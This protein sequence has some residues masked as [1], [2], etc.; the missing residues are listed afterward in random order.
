VNG[1]R[2]FCLYTIAALV[3]ASGCSKRTSDG[4]PSPRAAGEGNLPA[5]ECPLREAGVDPQHLKPFED[6]EKYIAFLDRPDRAVWQKPDDVVRA[7]Q[8]GG[9]E[10]IADVGAGSGYFT[11]RFAAALPRG[12]VVAI[13]IEPEMIRHIHHK[14]MTE[15]VTNIEPVLASVDDP[16]VPATAD[17]VF[18]CDV[19]HHVQDRQAWLERLHDQMKPGARLVL[20]EFKE[21]DLPE[22][23]PAALKISH[24]D[25]LALVRDAGFTFVSED[26]DLLPYQGFL[27]FRK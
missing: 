1:V 5:I 20:V 23:P 10:V 6:T 15:G 2:V 8:L 11:F 13:D 14:A 25:M 4:T 27:V 3:C 21:G 19:L 16:K 12:R 9:S 7:L 24:D 22:G 26:G 18:L 17:I